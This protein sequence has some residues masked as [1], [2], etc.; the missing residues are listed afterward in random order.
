[1]MMMIRS[2]ST[3]VTSQLTDRIYHIQGAP[4]K[5]YLSYIYYIVRE[6]SLFGPPG[7][8]Y[9][10]SA[11]IQTGRDSHWTESEWTSL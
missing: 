4:K 2:S 5:W 8:S 10:Q 9:L 6:V 1:M 3:V 7:I 11:T